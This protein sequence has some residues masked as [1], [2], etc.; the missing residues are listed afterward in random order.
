MHKKIMQIPSDI[1]LRLQ[2]YDLTSDLEMPEEIEKKMEDDYVKNP[3]RYNR[4]ILK[5]LYVN[6]IINEA[7]NEK[8]K[9]EDLLRVIENIQK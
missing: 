1:E 5:I 3:N 7:N 6:I 2:Y 4:N 8:T 9:F